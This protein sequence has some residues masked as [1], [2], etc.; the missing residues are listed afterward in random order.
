MKRLFLRKVILIVVIISLF[1]AIGCK[2]GGPKITTVPAGF[3]A[4][5]DTTNKFKFAYPEGWNLTAFVAQGGC[6]I[7]VPEG[8]AFFVKTR[9][10][11]ALTMENKTKS[12][13]FT[14]KGWGDK[15]VMHKKE[16]TTLSGHGAQLFIYTMKSE[17][18]NKTQYL[19]YTIANGRYYEL[20][21]DGKEEAYA[22]VKAKI[23]T[24]VDTFHIL[25]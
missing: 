20:I 15:L 19:I 25:G 18:G 16:S 4:Y 8:G 3:K 24:V 10:A 11:Q 1:V 21:Y 9:K 23:Q 2:K 12:F 22:K 14:F 5:E 6:N 7:S 13:N 17:Y